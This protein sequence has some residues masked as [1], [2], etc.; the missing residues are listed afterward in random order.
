MYRRGKRGGRWGGS[1]YESDGDSDDQNLPPELKWKQI[2]ISNAK[3]KERA[4]RQMVSLEWAQE[5]DIQRLLQNIKSSEECPPQAEN[6]GASLTDGWYENNDQK[7]PLG[8]KLEVPESFHQSSSQCFLDQNVSRH[9]SEEKRP[10]T[11]GSSIAQLSASS[12]DRLTMDGEVGEQDG[13]TVNE[14]PIL[15]ERFN[16]IKEETDF[17]TKMEEEEKLRNKLRVD[18]ALDRLLQDELIKKEGDPK[19]QQM[20]IIRRSLPSYERKDAI[21]DAIRNNQCVVISGETGCGKTTQVPQFILDDH[22]Q[23]GVGSHCRVLCTQPRRISAVSV[24]ERVAVERA[25]ECG[26]S[27]GY[28]IRLECKVSRPQGSILFCTTGILLKFLESD[29]LL[30]RASHIILDEIHERD[31]HSD[32]LMIILKDLLPKR[33][34]LKLILMSATLNADSFSQYFYKCPILNISGFTFP[35]EEYLLEDVVE[36]LSYK[37]EHYSRTKS[38]SVMKESGKHC[39][40]LNEIEEDLWLFDSWLK[41]KSLSVMEESGKHCHQLNSIEEKQRIFDAW[42]KDLKGKFSPAT[43]E[44]L[45]NMNFDVINLDLIQ[46]LIKYIV[47]KKGDGAILVFVPGLEDITQLYKMLML[48]IMLNFNSVSYLLVIIIPSKMLQWITSFSEN[49]IIIPLHSLMPTFNQKEVFER[50]P[51]GVRKIVIATS[52]AETSITIDDVVYVIDCGKIKVKDFKPEHNLASL[53]PQWV[54]K[55]NAKQ[56]RGRAGRTHLYHHIHRARQHSMKHSFICC[57]DWASE[58]KELGWLFPPPYILCGV[59]SSISSRGHSCSCCHVLQGPGIKAVLMLQHG[60]QKMEKGKHPYPKHL[61]KGKRHSYPP[62][63]SAV[64]DSMFAPCLRMMFCV[65]HQ[66]WWSLRC[67]TVQTEVMPPL[68]HSTVPFHSSSQMEELWSFDRVINEGCSAF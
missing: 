3:R 56:R 22:I 61:R 65:S 19:Y 33:P 17:V 51:S 44:A 42:L 12:L 53:K 43:I 50:P 21:L 26:I 59:G 30:D 52:I 36:M 18:S 11:A 1:N 10:V 64:R 15:K 31:L 55:A 7:G 47:L 4:E 16:F 67:V 5:E 34:D 27:S 63:E 14:F 35:V 54:S 23:R 9:P 45:C 39:D 37:S 48:E 29:P 28:M 24:A 13:M 68:I 66:S 49:F 8:D 62:L 46:A 32:F 58:G 60:V 40:E 25:E 57:T 38:Q 41:T 6:S 2:G 20:Q